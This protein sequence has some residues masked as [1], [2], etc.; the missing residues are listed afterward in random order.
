M[1]EVRDVPLDVKVHNSV[2]RRMRADERYR[3]G[4][5]IVSGR[6]RGTRRAPGGKGIG[7][8][9]VLEEGRGHPIDEVFVRR[10]VREEIV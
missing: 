2:I 9:E 6:G 5:L 1:G 3:L 7:E 4:N 10:G 8:W